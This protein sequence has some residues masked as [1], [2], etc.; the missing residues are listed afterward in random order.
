MLGGGSSAAAPAPQAAPQAPGGGFGDAAGGLVGGLGGLLDRL[1]SAGHGQVAQSWVGT[2]PN[3]PIQPSQLGGALGQTT[4]SELAR[5]AGMSEQDL[6][7][8]LSQVLPGVVD[9]LTPQGQVP[10]H[11]EVSSVWGRMQG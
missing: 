11:A 10:P 6:L 8:Q 5:Q 1:T 4:V 2:G 3:T 7:A 9:K